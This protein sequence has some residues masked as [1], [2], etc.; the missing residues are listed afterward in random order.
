MPP[1]AFLT[2]KRHAFVQRKLSGIRLSIR[3]E[4]PIPKEMNHPEITLRVPV[5]NEMQL[6]FASEPCKPLKPR[7]I[8]VVFIVEKDV[9]VE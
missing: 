1:A 2:P 3:T 4:H 9:R 7:F 5:V 8:G 6:L